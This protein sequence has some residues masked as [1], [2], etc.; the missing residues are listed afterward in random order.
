MR[1]SLFVT[2][3]VC[4]VKNNQRELK[5]TK[6]V[7]KISLVRKIVAQ[8]VLSLFVL[9]SAIAQTPVPMST[10]PSLTYTEG[11]ADIANWT[12]GFAAGIGAS[13][14]GGVAITATGTIGDGT[15]T[16]IATTS[17]Q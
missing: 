10:Q 2:A 12:N 5:A 13:R 11:F 6:S 3:N 4:L 16:T 15:K 1:K 14:W 17:F 9:H 8:L 7:T